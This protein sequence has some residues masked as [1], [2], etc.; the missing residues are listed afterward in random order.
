VSSSRLRKAYQSLGQKIKENL[1]RS[2]HPL[3]TP[4]PERLK[5]SLGEHAFENE[6]D[7][8]AA[9]EKHQTVLYLAYGS[10]LCYQTF[11]ESRGIKPISQMNVV[12]PEL[13]MTFDL[14]GIPYS[15]PCFANSARRIPSDL[16]IDNEDARRK[17]YNK[18]KWKKGMVGV[19][20]EVTPSDYAHI[21]ATEG[22]GSAY[23]DILVSCHPLSS[24]VEVP[25]IP[26]T[27]SFKAH[28]LFAPAILP[29]G[30][31]KPPK[32]G[33][34]FQRP[35]PSYAQA[36]SRYLKLIT[37]GADEHDLPQ[38]YKDYLHGIRPYTIT[39][40]GQRL[41]QFVFLTFWAPFI[42][43]LF[44]LQRRYQDNKGRA[45]KWLAALSNA[46]FTSVW[47]SYD[48]FFMP[49][50]G[51]GERTMRCKHK[52]GRKQSM[53]RWRG[54]SRNDEEWAEKAKGIQKDEKTPMED[55]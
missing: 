24:N 50:F 6:G 17:E 15:E 13:R 23:Q 41:G 8:N 38:E 14:P 44:A 1:P 43:F 11:Q 45:P 51:D 28:T 40:Q 9:R 47:T 42:F 29:P 16:K 5:A 35:D 22:G 55:F 46:L 2:I 18:D 34:R 12:V 10:N 36:S 3:P 7:L 20:Y 54:V 4:S 48:N 31:G 26:T 39:T 21:I 37:D 27:A 53:G 33:G 52:H 32:V 25:E 49:L 19:V 30:S